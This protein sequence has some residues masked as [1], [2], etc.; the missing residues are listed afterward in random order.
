MRFLKKY[1]HGGSHNALSGINFDKPKTNRQLRREEREDK[2]GMIPARFRN[3][4][5]EG[6]D[7]Y[8]DMMRKRGG[9]SFN[10]AD[11]LKSFFQQKKGSTQKPGATAGMKCTKYGCGAFD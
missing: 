9:K 8:R 2:E 3:R 5:Q 7:D 1:E 11:A 10:L 4:G 6:L